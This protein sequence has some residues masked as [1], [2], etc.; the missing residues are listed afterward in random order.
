M[1][2]LCGTFMDYSMLMHVRVY[3][4]SGVLDHEG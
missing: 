3:V 4:Y 2:I 1:D